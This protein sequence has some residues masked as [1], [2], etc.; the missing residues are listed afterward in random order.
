VSGNP[1]SLSVQGPSAMIGDFNR[2]HKA[3]FIVNTSSGGAVFLGNG[4]GTFQPRINLPAAGS[5][6]AA[7]DFNGDRI[8][9]LIVLSGG[10]ATVLLG[11][12]DGT[13][14]SGTMFGSQATAAGDFKGDG[15]PDFVNVLT[16]RTN[17]CGADPC[18]GY[19][20]T[21]VFW[22]AHGDGTFAP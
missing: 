22:P 11:N 18:S 2:D 14:R 12:G 15:K 8:T 3:D 19:Q 7:T 5:P 21:L 16:F 1:M 9:D 13:F 17:L 20:S 10:S 4:D 6:Q